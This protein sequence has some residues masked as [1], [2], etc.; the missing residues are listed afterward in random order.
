MMNSPP[1]SWKKHL[2]AGLTVSM[3]TGLALCAAT[4]LKLAISAPLAGPALVC[5][6]LIAWIAEVL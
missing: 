6:P 1:P 2:R 4:V 3:V 5:L